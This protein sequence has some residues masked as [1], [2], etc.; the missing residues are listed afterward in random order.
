MSKTQF[1]RL[2]A[3]LA[4]ILG[5]V[6]QVKLFG[7]NMLL[8]YTEMSNILVFSFMIFLVI[9]EW[10]YGKTSNNPRLT[11]VKGGI[12]MAITITFMVYHFMLRPY[13]EPESFWN[14]SNLLVHYVAPLCMIFDTLCLDKVKTYYWFDPFIWT[15]IPLAYFGFGLYNGLVLQWEIPGT[16]DSPFPYYFINVTKY[17]ALAV[18]QVSAI[19][20][21]L[22]VLIGYI[23]LTIKRFVG[24][25]K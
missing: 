18:A 22:Y 2:L 21:V 10:I 12:T 15:L 4:G 25:K 7:I 14:F 6:F 16:P 1:F 11:R 9:Y 20:A 17:G 23:L 8:Y 5:V 13:V 3:A 19:I 24:S